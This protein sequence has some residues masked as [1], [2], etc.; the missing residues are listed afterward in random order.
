MLFIIMN[1]TLEN[2]INSMNQR[3]IVTIISHGIQ[4]VKVVFS[5]LNKRRQ[6]N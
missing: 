3:I 2:V 5:V 1:C 6:F 4:N